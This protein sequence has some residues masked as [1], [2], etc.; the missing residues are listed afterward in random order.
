M[1]GF[2]ASF[3]L[4]NERLQ[5]GHL[6][7]HG[8]GLLAPAQL[9]AAP[10]AHSSLPRLLPTF[11]LS[12]K[13]VPLSHRNAK[14]FFQVAQPHHFSFHMSGCAIQQSFVGTCWEGGVFFFFPASVPGV[15]TN[16]LRTKQGAIC[17]SLPGHQRPFYCFYTK[18]FP[19]CLLFVLVLTNVSHKRS[20]GKGEKKSHICIHQQYYFRQKN[21]SLRG[22]SVIQLS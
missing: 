4:K 19:F 12:S 18:I 16:G 2:A 11:F 1:T 9:P 10:H 14:P 5:K 17:T 15:Q 13:A 6:E 21:N 3:L 8:C 20:R 7:K 22:I